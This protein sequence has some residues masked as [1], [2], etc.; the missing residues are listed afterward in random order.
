MP[1]GIVD[2]PADVWESLIAIGDEARGDWPGRARQAAIALT[3]ETAETAFTLG[4]TLLVD[5][6]HVFDH[7]DRLL[8][9][10][11]LERLR[12]RGKPLGRP[13]P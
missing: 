7:T 3:A 9:K 12:D 2:R 13:R 8:T 10:D 1:D 5:C 4:V 11:L 6:R